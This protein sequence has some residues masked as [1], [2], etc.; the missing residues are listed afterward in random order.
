MGGLW[1][2]DILIRSY[3]YFQLCENIG[4]LMLLLS[5]SPLHHN[6]PKKLI[7]KNYILKIIT[8]ISNLN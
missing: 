1:D 3:S 4:L 7:K 2:K 5:F 8:L 6:C